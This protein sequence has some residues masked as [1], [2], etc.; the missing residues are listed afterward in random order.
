MGTEE[1]KAQW[2]NVAKDTPYDFKPELDH[3]MKVTATNLDNAEATLG[4][5]MVQ[6]SSDPICSSAGCTQYEWP[7]GPKSHPVDYFVPN[8]GADPDMETTVNSLA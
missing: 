7:K 6:T 2:H 3:D 1:S 5:T 4:T 8:F